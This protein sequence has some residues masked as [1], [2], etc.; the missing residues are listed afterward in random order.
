MCRLQNATLSYSGNLFDVKHDLYIQ[1]QTDMKDPVDIHISP[2]VLCR[3]ELVP[4]E[5]DNHSDASSEYEY[6]STNDDNVIILA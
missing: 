1:V 3:K 5:Q 2:I 6:P 4:V